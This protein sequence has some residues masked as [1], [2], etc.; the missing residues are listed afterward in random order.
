MYLEPEVIESSWNTLST[1]EH[2]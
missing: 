1:C 2:R